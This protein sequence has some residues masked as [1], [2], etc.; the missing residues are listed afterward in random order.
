M[1]FLQELTPWVLQ[2]QEPLS[3]L[4]EILTSLWMTLRI[5]Q[6]LPQMS[7]T[8]HPSLLAW[9]ISSLNLFNVWRLTHLLEQAFTFYSL[10][11]DSFSRIDSCFCYCS[12]LTLVSDL[13]IL[14]IAISDHSPILITLLDFKLP[15]TPRLW[16]FPSC[17]ADNEDFHHTMYLAGNDYVFT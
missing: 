5:S 7:S 10:Q 6:A 16:H 3:L 4:G 12:L 17:L 11:H 1:S 2:S 13:D 15:S 8:R 9:T 14:D